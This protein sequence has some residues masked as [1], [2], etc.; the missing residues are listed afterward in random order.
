[1]NIEIK[2][3]KGKIRRLGRSRFGRV[4]SLTG[5]F[6]VITAVTYGFLSLCYWSLDL[7]AW[8]GFGRFILAFEG[9]IYVVKLIDEW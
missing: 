6:L 2:M 1:M 5:T 3:G 4:M 8:G 7:T 9:V